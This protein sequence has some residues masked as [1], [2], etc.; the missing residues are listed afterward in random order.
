MNDDLL[1]ALR[2]LGSDV[3][4]GPPDPGDLRRVRRG[5][6]RRRRTRITAVSGLAVVA[7]AGAA[8]ALVP[9][10]RNQAMITPTSPSP[11]ITPTS[12]SP[13]I[14]ATSPSPTI[15]ATS[16]S[17]TS[18]RTVTAPATPDRYV[19]VPEGG[20]PAT[21]LPTPAD[22]GDLVLRSAED[23]STIRVLVRPAA[24]HSVITGAV[25]ASGRFAYYLVQHTAGPNSSYAAFR[26]PVSGGSPQALGDPPGV[27]ASP[28]TEPPPVASPDDQLIAWSTSSGTTITDARGR[29]RS[30]VDGTVVGFTDNQHM[31]VERIVYGPADR[32]ATVELFRTLVSDPGGGTRFY[33]HASKAEPI[34]GAGPCVSPASTAAG[35]LPD[36]KVELVTGGCYVGNALPPTAHVIDPADGATLESLPLPSRFGGFVALS[37]NTTPAG[38][39]VIALSHQDCYTSPPTAIVRDQRIVVPA[40]D[41]DLC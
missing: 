22:A 31:V 35:L 7:V 30:T 9:G 26:V 24:G 14:T 8:I 29:V 18:S 15:T 13:T 11:T 5:I 17:P 3:G 10:S 1:A 40:Y 27:P 34:A 20:G 21:S 19:D 23:G 33:D 4:S 38:S 37:V 25:G 32:D 16:P 36:G 12:P 2:G 6:T 28:G 41:S 39:A